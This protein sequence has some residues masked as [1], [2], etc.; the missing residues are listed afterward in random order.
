MA[1]NDFTPDELERLGNIADGLTD[2]LRDSEQMTAQLDALCA[3]MGRQ[4]DA[5]FAE[6]MKD[7][8]KREAELE[9]SLRALSKL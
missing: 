8:P 9:A 5:W 4:A 7:A 3:E 1:D 6:W 2:L